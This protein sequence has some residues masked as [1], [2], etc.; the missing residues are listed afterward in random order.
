MY[1][2]PQQQHHRDEYLGRTVGRC[3]LVKR[4]G[5][6]GM[7]SVY[8]GER[9]G[10]GAFLKQL[11]VKVVHV[12]PGQVSRAGALFHDEARIAASVDHPN[13]CRLV[14]FGAERDGTLYTVMELL[15]GATFAQALRVPGGVPSWLAVRVVA[16][17]ARGLHAVH[18]ARGPDHARLG[19]IHR[20]VSPANLFVSSSGHTQICD[21]GIATM[22]GARQTA[23]G[24]ELRGKI[25][26]MAPELFEN[27]GEVDRRVD[28]WGLG[29]VL[30]EAIAGE[31]LFGSGLSGS[32]GGNARSRMRVRPP[33][34]LRGA[35]D[36]RLDAIVLQALAPNPAQRFL[37][38]GALADALDE[39]LH[40]QRERSS[41]ARVASW[42]QGHLGLDDSATT[43]QLDTDDIEEVRSGISSRHSHTEI[44]SKAEILTRPGHLT[45]A[46][47]RQLA[48]VVVA[49][50]GFS[51]L[52]II[53]AALLAAST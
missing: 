2:V 21:F 10:P 17:A 35:G 38:A 9:V 31:R 20:D 23:R 46:A 22:R 26:Y 14:D 52:S 47:Q 37:T 40:R 33:S 5:T 48:I 29:V 45:L 30:W 28:V 19:I 18:E 51:A 42:I 25:A 7:G 3:R 16:D 43:L 41:H 50:A 36:A 4:L 34:H 8:L 12:P 44:L 32:S 39:W 11:A 15:R 1:A 6:G 13:V 53:L 27:R 24:S 49:A